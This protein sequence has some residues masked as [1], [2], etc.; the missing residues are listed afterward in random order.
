M[1]FHV[2]RE[3]RDRLGIEGELFAS[4]GN[5]ILPDFRASRL[6]ARRINERMDAALLPERAVRAGRLNA[7]ALIDEVLHYVAHL[8]RDRASPDAFALALSD[9]EASLGRVRT[10]ELLLAFV[11]RFPPA[12]VYAGKERARAW[13]KAS[14]KGAPNREAALEEMLL[15]RLANENPAF[16]PF[17]FLFDEAVLAV[18]GRPEAEDYAASIPIL[19]RRFA[20]LPSFGQDV[21]D[22]LS[23]L[24]SPAAASPLSLPGRSDV[25]SSHQTVVPN[26]SVS[27][28]TGSVR[29]RHVRVQL[30]G[31][32]YL[33]M[34]EVQVMGH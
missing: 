15:L 6:L 10:D 29:G 20:A 31:T 34:A 14:S 25:W 2:S 8:F 28:A 4:T 23:M 30:S 7:M 12:S 13:L 3:A 21:Q 32:D 11:E 19:E 26:P 33:N 5:V 1:E 18:P 22:L 27:I 17:R 16:A 9:L 24:R